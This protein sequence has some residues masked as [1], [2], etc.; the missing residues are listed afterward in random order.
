MWSN[1]DQKILNQMMHFLKAQLKIC[2]LKV[3][4]NDNYFSNSTKLKL[5]ALGLVQLAQNCY[6]NQDIVFKI[7]ITRAAHTMVDS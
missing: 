3:R 1:V 6:N 7:G 2:H 4:I 5:G